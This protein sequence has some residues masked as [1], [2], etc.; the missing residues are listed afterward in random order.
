MKLATAQMLAEF[1][2]DQR[3]V[4]KVVLSAGEVVRAGNLSHALVGRSL[5]PLA[6]PPW[7]APRGS[8]PT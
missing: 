1:M 7:G 3:R 4:W 2:A 6:S 5:P 8:Q